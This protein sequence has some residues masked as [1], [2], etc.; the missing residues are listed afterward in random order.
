VKYD[1]DTEA[2][3]NAYR[4][5]VWLEQ[6]TTAV[7]DAKAAQ[8]TNTLLD[9]RIKTAVDAE[10]AARGMTLVTENPDLLVVYHT[11]LDRKIDVTDWGYTYPR[12]P[13]GG[14]Y[15]GQ[16]DVY[17][18]NE[19]TL[20]VDLIDAKS[21]Q[22]VWRGTATKVIDETATTEEREANLR[23]VMARLFENYPPRR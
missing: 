4:S 11:G 16:V 12:Y 6:P 18:Y 3:F 7:G 22:L 17:E 5:Y 13:Y 9:K 14:W 10:L 1:F 15:G 23:E 20:I 8:R 2:D 21:D 19:G